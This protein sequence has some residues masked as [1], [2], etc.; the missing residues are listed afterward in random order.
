MPCG[1]WKPPTVPWLVC[2]HRPRL[3]LM[4]PLKLVLQSVT[5][6]ATCEAICAGK[7]RCPD[8]RSPP[9]SSVGVPGNHARGWTPSLYLE[10]QRLW[11]WGVP[12]TPLS[13]PFT[14][15]FSLG[16]FSQHTEHTVSTH[17]TCS[18]PMTQTHASHRTHSAHGHSCS[19]YFVGIPCLCSQTERTPF[20][21]SAGWWL[22]LI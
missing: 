4:P 9:T 7:G 8:T 15:P 5:L 14:S 18:A 20:R 21:T 19:C 22:R 13:S 6:V 3:S 17:M 12:M 11:G 10:L 16:R 1:V 2:S